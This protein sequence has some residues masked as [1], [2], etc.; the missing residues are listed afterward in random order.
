METFLGGSVRD[1][2]L[3]TEALR[4][5]PTAA[6]GALPVAQ[7]AGTP[8]RGQNGPKV[9]T[10]LVLFVRAFSFFF[11]GG[12]SKKDTTRKVHFFLKS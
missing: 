2:R 3:A 10:R 9:T 12:G 8:G 1:P 7:R 6:P 5:D 4:A 11:L